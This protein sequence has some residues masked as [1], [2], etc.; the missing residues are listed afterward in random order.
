MLNKKYKEVFDNIKIDKKIKEE[1]LNNILNKNRKNIIFSKP[2][3]IAY[4]LLII[5]IGC[6]IVTAIDKGNLFN[7]LNVEYKENEN[8]I[9]KTYLSR[10]VRAEVNYTAN[11]PEIKWASTN[12]NIYSNDELSKLLGIKF[13][14]SD[15]F[16][17]NNL[18]QLVTEKVDNNISNATFIKE[19]CV[20]SN[21]YKLIWFIV[22]FKTK[23]YTNNIVDNYDLAYS[24][25]SY[26]FYINNL[27]TM[28]VVSKMGNTYAVAFV[29]DDVSY[30]LTISFLHDT[31]EEEYDSLT[32]DILN[33]LHY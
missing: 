8:G 5:F 1:N 3:F 2:V 23:Y 9:I 11:I 15:L 33:S 16:I 25:D 32:S 13:L 22:S 7:G 14:T 18:K 30:S 31:L 19:D 28:S 17:D 20:D 27:N 4:S 10:D 21:K 26:E 12:A 6:G 29:Y 24:D